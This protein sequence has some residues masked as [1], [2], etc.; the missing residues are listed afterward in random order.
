MTDAHYHRGGET[1]ALLNGREFRF[2]G[3]H[4]WRVEDVDLPAEI[5]RLKSPRPCDNERRSSE[6]NPEI[7]GEIKEN[8]GVRC[9]ILQ[10]MRRRILTIA[11]YLCII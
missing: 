7:G 10:N 9:N 3:I 6:L 8:P 5:G 2:C 4:P 1:L 11:P